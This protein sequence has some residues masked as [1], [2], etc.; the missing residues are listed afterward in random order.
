MD[1]LFDTDILSTFAKADMI[2]LLE[3]L[4][5]EDN[6]Y[7]TPAIIEELKVPKEFGYNF[8]DLILN[9]EKFNIISLNETELKE[10]KVKL[11]K[12]DKLHKG[13]IEALIICKNRRYAFSSRDSD[14]LK[15]AQSEGITVI[16]LHSILK[17]LWYFRILPKQE[18]RNLINAMEKEDNLIIKNKE[19]IFEE[20]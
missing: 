20:D 11:L 18:V 14:A 15:F 9:S 7:I 4:Y 8:P 12:Q 3:E 19:V 13:E 2:K 16:S 1:I 10:F 17:A 5:S 6:L